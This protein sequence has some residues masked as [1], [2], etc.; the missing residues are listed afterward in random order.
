MINFNHDSRSTVTNVSLRNHVLDAFC[1]QA[2]R[3]N[4]HDVVERHLRLLLSK[5]NRG[6]V[7]NHKDEDGYAAIHYAAK[8]NRYRIMIQLVAAGAGVHVCV[9]VCVCVCVRHACE[10][11]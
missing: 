7:L 9:R 8:F 6:R 3:D 11:V 5:R 2:A 10:Y 1:L 4:R